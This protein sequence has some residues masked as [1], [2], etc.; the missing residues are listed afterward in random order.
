MTSPV[1]GYKVTTSF[2]VPGSWAAGEHTG[3]DYACPVGTPVVAAAGG[4]IVKAGNQG[5]YGNRIDIRCH[6]DSC[7]HSYSHLSRFH[8]KVG[9]VVGAGQMIGESGNTGRSTGPHCHYEERH[10]P[11]GYYDYR[12][13]HHS[14]SDTAPTPEPPPKRRRKATMILAKTADDGAIYLVGVSGAAHVGTPPAVDEI[15]LA[16]AD[17]NHIAVV[18]DYTLEQLIAAG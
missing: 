16:L 13:P 4:T 9:Q 5:D 14:H 3:E 17:P 15:K 1:P 12:A 2:G 7:E 10:T 11:Y 8:V 18:D 6:V